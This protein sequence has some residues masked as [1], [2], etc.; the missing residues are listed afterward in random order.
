MPTQEQLNALIA[1][2]VTQGRSPDEILQGL[3]TAFSFTD[4]Q[5]LE[6]VLTSARNRG[7][8]SVTVAGN[9]FDFGPATGE[10][11]LL[12]IPE[13]P[14]GTITGPTPSPTPTPAPPPFEDPFIPEVPSPE[15]A[16]SRFVANQPFATTPG[17]RSAAGR[18][19]PLL[20]TQFALQPAV[21]GQGFNEFGDF[22]NGGSRLTG[23]A[24]QQRLAEVTNAVS[25]P[26][27][28]IQD[29]F[30]LALQEQ[31][32]DPAN[33]FAAFTLPALQ[34][35]GGQGRRLLQQGFNRFQDRFLGQNPLASGEDVARLFGSSVL[36]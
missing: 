20:E 6:I 3:K 12:P 23:G 17:I 35:A 7:Q 9:T 14:E 29:P 26:L 8:T 31:F 10:Q 5:A 27:G 13:A 21:A 34:A 32:I 2:L 25:Q 28:S 18:L 33:A 36:R 11:Q 1:Q 19:R 16:F 15:Q 4:Q 30:M 24:L 22:L